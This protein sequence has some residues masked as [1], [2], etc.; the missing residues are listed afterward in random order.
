MIDKKLGLLV[1]SI[2]NFGSKGFY[3]LQEV[4]LAK[5]LCV[6]FKE[7]LVYRLIPYGQP[8]V[9]E[10]INNN[11]KLFLLPSRKIGSNGIPNFS[12]LDPSIDILICFSDTQLMFPK[13]YSWCKKNNILLF[14]YIG[15]TKS[16]SRNFFIRLMI[17]FFYLRNLSIY[18]RVTCFAKTPFVKGKLEKSGVKDVFLAPIGLDI[19]LMKK[20]YS[21]YYPSELK[22]SFGFKDKDK[23]ILFVGRFTAEKKPLD[24]LSIFQQVYNLD[25]NYRLLMVGSGELSEKVKYY[26]DGL[27]LKSVVKEIDQIPNAEMWKLYRF[28]DC[29]VNL[30]DHEIYGMA[31]LEALFYDCKV[32][33]WYAPGP[34]YL[35]KNG[36][37]GWLVSNKTELIDKIIDPNKFNT[38]NYILNHF[39]WDYSSSVVVKVIASFMFL[40]NQ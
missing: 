23:V 39:M 21:E 4:G 24:M 16:N 31:I 10:P 1:L 26:I 9:V 30:N 33:A 36:I 17:N 15:V 29:F 40:R 13:V 32:I 35:I 18:K 34:N 27:N 14:P 20:D 8:K 37:S 38:N 6:Y 3:N 7:I 25:N 22:R 19:D 2:G 28:A 5:A 11:S 12:D